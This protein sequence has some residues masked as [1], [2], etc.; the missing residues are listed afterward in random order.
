MM[1]KFFLVDFPWAGSFAIDSAKKFK[2]VRIIFL[3]VLISRCGWALAAI[4]PD[5]ALNELIEGNKRFFSAKSKHT[6]WEE[7]ARLLKSGTQT[8]LA[9]ILGCSDSRVPPE[10]IFDQG[11]GD[12][13]VIRVAGN[14]IGDIELSSI[15]FGV[16]KFKIPLII[17]LGHQECGA[18][19]TVLKQSENASGLYAIY[20]LIASAIAQCKNQ[21]TKDKLINA[22]HCNI[23][24]SM[25]T[26]ITT[27]LLASAIKE[28]KLQVV[29]GYYDF[30]SG[31]VSLVPQ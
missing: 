13:F 5:D 21:N 8:P 26:L 31:K 1:N 12:L 30:K 14:V 10:I 3:L 23:R 27:P 22:I 4:S 16:S 25:Q 2:F 11:L 19:Q 7:E 24:G 17:V 9:I 28:N 20:P 18:V 15:E 6:H 29:G